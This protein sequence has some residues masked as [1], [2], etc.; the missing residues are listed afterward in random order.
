VEVVVAGLGEDGDRAGGDRADDLVWPAPGWV[1][2][3]GGTAAAALLVV[4]SLVFWRGM[5]T[6]L[7]DSVTEAFGVVLGVLVVLSG[8]GAFH[9]AAVESRT[10]ESR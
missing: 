9:R 4:C 1:V 5:G 2:P 8:I 10:V 6:N 3:A 7:A